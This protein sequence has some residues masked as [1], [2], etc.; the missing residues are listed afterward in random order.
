MDHLPTSI[1]GLPVD[2]PFYARQQT[3]CPD[4]YFKIPL[5]FGYNDIHNLMTC[6]LD[7]KNNQSKHHE[8]LQSWLFFGLLSQVLGTEI[9]HAAFLNDRDCTLHTKTLNSLLDEWAQKEKNVEAHGSKKDLD[10]Q[11]HRYLK[12]SRA[13]G[14]ARCFITKYCSAR[15]LDREGRDK[16]FPDT[17]IQPSP[18]QDSNTIQLNEKMTLSL[19]VLG[20]TL[21]QARPGLNFALEESTKFWNDTS[22]EHKYW[23]HSKYSR[24]KMIENHLCKFDIWRIESTMPGVSSVFYASSMKPSHTGADH[25]ACT[26]K[27]CKQQ[28]L[29]P[30]PFHMAKCKKSKCTR[31]DIPGGDAKLVEIIRSGKTPLVTWTNQGRLKCEGYDLKTNKVK[32]GALSHSW[33]E[34]IVDSGRDARDKNDRRMHE[35]QIEELQRSFNRILK[36]GKAARVIPFWVDILCLPRQATVKDQGVN[37]IRDIYSKAEAVLVWDRKLLERQRTPEKDAIEM[38]VLIRIGDWS[39]RLWTL[40]EAVLAPKM[41]IACRNDEVSIEVLQRAGD[42]ARDDPNDEYHHI[43]KAGHP[44]SPEIWALRK[45]ITT[46]NRVQRAWQAVQFRLVT[47]PEDETL[48][49]AS[50]LGLDVTEIHKIGRNG[51]SGEGFAAQRMVRFLS[52]LDSTPGLGIPAGIIFMQTPRLSIEGVKETKGYGWA[53][54]TWLSRNTDVYPLFHT[55]GQ[56]G[57]IM[58]R[59]LLVKFP[60]LVLHCPTVAIEKRKFW[61]PVCQSGHKWYK[62][63]V[64]PPSDRD[65]KIFWAEVSTLSEVSIIMSQSLPRERWDIGVLVHTKGKLTQGRV[66]LVAILCRV[67]IRLETNPNTLTKLLNNMR[68][69]SDTMPLGERLASGTEWCID[70]GDEQETA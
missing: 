30:N 28:E 34:Q 68:E 2:V 3:F 42:K 63:V 58:Q 33:Q 4:D 52:M 40:Q 17:K 18:H 7:P 50:I 37:Q 60:G 12:A 19:A 46:E 27:E 67:W 70:G 66:R 69:K 32:F 15:P 5:E 14:E 54:R 23:G 62:V 65:W 38:N 48:I 36:E 59:G 25:S 6:G 10:Q 35:C 20:E 31:H 8:F 22:T 57:Q 51:Y 53:P 9:D 64:D 29:S 44:F 43:W 39:R 13:L 47:Y 45:G 55:P 26:F 61:V 49:L 41:Y 16:D 21:Q 11:K 56:T 24:N 1:D